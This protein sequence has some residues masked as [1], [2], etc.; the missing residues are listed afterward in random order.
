MI[1]EE[2]SAEIGVISSEKINLHLSQEKKDAL[3]TQFREKPPL[4]IAG[5]KVVETK[6][7][8]GVKLLFA[9]SSWLLVRPSG[10]E[11]LIRAYFEAETPK[12]LSEINDY[13]QSL[14]R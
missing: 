8:D 2:F 9:D 13:L 6:T 5:V 7:I 3:M 12:R 10:T 11:P 14:V 4:E 1:W